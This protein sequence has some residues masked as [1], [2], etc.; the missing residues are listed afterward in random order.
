VVSPDINQ[1]A[2]G[3]AYQAVDDAD[4]A[5]Y[6]KATASEEWVVKG[7]VIEQWVPR[8]ARE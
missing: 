5:R 3:F 7:V 1:Q 8:V 4:I 6:R 2:V